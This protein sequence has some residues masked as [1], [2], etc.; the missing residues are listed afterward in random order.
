MD[1]NTVIKDLTILKI[2]KQIESRE[3][4]ESRIDI[5]EIINNKNRMV[6]Y[7]IDKFYMHQNLS[8]SIV[9]IIKLIMI[10]K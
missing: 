9:R 5:E 2:E 3:N 8:I 6:I 4:K 1:G 10:Q 7:M